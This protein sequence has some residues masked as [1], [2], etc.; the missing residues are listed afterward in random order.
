MTETPSGAL[1]LLIAPIF[2]QWAVTAVLLLSRLVNLPG[3]TAAGI[4]FRMTAIS[5]TLLLGFTVSSR[6]AVTTIRSF[7]FSIPS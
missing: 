5:I 6:R 1:L 2:S 7:R 3:V 4:P